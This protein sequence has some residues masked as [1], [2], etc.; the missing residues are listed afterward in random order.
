MTKRRRPAA[1]HLKSACALALAAS[2]SVWAQSAL[3]GGSAAQPRS[4]NERI[5]TEAATPST[6]NRQ[7]QKDE[8][9][10]EGA[11][12][13]TPVP[14]IP[15]GA[16]GSSAVPAPAPVPGAAPVIGPDGVV[17]DDARV[18]AVP[19][20]ARPMMAAGL[21]VAMLIEHALGMA[22][23]ANALQAIAATD[24]AMAGP[25]KELFE[26]GRRELQGSRDLLVRA[27]A[28]GRSVPA[29]SPTRRFYDAANAYVTALSA[30]SA[31]SPAPP[32]ELA[33]VAMINHAVHEV[34]DANH[35]A[36]MGRVYG[37]S[38]ASEQLVQHARK[39]KDGATQT[40]LRMAGNVTPGTNPP[41]GATTLAMYGRDLIEAADQIAASV[42]APGAM[43]RSAVPVGV[44]GRDVPNSVRM[45]AVPGGLPAHG[46]LFEAPLAQVEARLLGIG[47]G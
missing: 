19:V 4:Q 33:R 44:D 6:I 25:S 5:N 30:M 38:A 8:A 18:G 7:I 42:P 27:A 14:N 34:L 36:S 13:A 3:T 20:G 31:A 45:P 1:L 10:A 46:T 26:H 16:V 17:V 21:D 41:P 43:M 40:V 32:A 29:A 9:A 28:D 35:I 37:G 11:R 24:P 15:P 2:P 12:P 39:M 23:E 47:R 22:I